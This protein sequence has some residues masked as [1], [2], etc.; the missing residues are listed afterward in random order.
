M[1][2]I[3]LAGAT[4][5]TGLVLLM[6]Y[7]T[8][9]GRTLAQP[10]A[11]TGPSATVPGATGTGPSSDPTP[12][13]QTTAPNSAPSGTYTG[14]AVMTTWGTVQ[15]QVT[16]TNGQVAD[17]HA[18][19]VPDGNARDAQINSYAVPILEAETVSANNSRIDA[20]SGA[21]VTSEGYIDSL[22]AALDQA[23]LR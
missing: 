9:T 15:V 8:S 6:S 11:D 2:K 10:P 20:V 1:R 16:V 18:I 17:A 4:T 13:Q 12:D 3:I 5:A 21:T 7:P 22:Q 14:P 23:G 19:Q